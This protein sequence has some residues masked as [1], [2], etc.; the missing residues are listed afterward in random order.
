MSPQ[1][2]DA[3]LVWALRVLYAATV[4][5]VGLWLAYFV[6]RMA[7]QQA[8]M[9]P[10]IDTTIGAFLARAV[11]YV[12]ITIVLIIVLQMFGVQTASLV[13]VLGASALAIGLA[14]QGTLS[15]VASGIMVALVRP[16]QI[17]DFVEING[18]EG[19]VTDLD[20]FFTEIRSSDNRRILVPN[21]QAIAHPITNH[22]TAGKRCCAL[23]VGV[24]YGD[25]LGRA[26]AVLKRVMT[27][28]PRASAK[29]A[30]WFGVQGLAE[31][32]VILSALVWVKT[33]EHKA[34]RADM[35]KAVKEA[36]DAER[37]KMRHPHEVQAS[38]GEAPLRPPAIK[39]SISDELKRAE[40]LAEDRR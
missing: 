39:Q 4:L 5:I 18:K 8:E 28:D 10:R 40:A 27:S 1:F 33:G 6:S 37:V 7:R 36:F 21:G 30:P 32:S 9:N 3:A 2:L 13:A 34:Y 19:L 23:T 14:L 24:S 11:R 17:G 20:L 25:D 22:T 35:F 31:S 12:L 38:Q 26:L 29:P 15:N 16:Y